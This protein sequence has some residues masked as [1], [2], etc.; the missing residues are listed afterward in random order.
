MIFEEATQPACDNYDVCIIGS[1]PVGLALASELRKTNLRILIVESGGRRP[2]QATQQLADAH[3]VDP[4]LHDDIR[5]CVSRQLGGTSNLWTGRCVPYDPVDFVDRFDDGKWPI[6]YADIVPY[7]DAAV[8]YADCGASIFQDSNPR[9]DCEGGQF[10][11]SRRERYSRNAK[12]VQSVFADTLHDKQL[13]IHLNLTVSDLVI[14]EDGKVE[15]VIASRLDGTKVM[16]SS[17][18]I[19]LAMGGLETTRLLLALQRCK[20]AL[21]GGAHGALGRYYMS[22]LFGQASQICFRNPE[23]EAAFN[24]ELDEHRSYIRRRIIPTDDQILRHKL[25]NVAFWPVVSQVAD[26]SHGSALLSMAY[27][28]VK[29][30]PL[31]RKLTPEVIRRH[32][33]MHRVNNADHVKNIV[34]NPFEIFSFLPQFIYRRYLAA[35]RRP[36][37]YAT[38]RRHLYGLY[39]HSEHFPERNSHVRLGHQYDALGLPRLEIDIKFS[40]E[41]ADALGRAHHLLNEWL[42]SSGCAELR[43]REPAGE[44]S[45]AI[46]ATARHGTHQIGT[47]RMGA[48]RHEAVVDRNLKVFDLKNLY[49]A[50]SSVFPTS[51]QANPTL[52]AMAFSVRLAQH[53]IESVF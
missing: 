43:F 38:N 41:N 20:P 53:L 17:K 31:G 42:R 26:P 8:Q 52:T 12:L 24:F 15:K 44:L 4:N 16:I 9:L 28:A 19:V 40:K 21:F 27:L 3:I 10:D 22:H 45:G 11:L 36:G 51:G 23:I 47:T 29:F 6:E 39:F 25:P 50:S 2:S 1:G 49:V 46:L 32:H 33:V 30:P 5:I 14:S 34:K 13:D 48:N 18:V 7:Y 37:F 35:V